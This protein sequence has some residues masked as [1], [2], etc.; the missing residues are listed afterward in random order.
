MKVLINPHG[1]GACPLCKFNNNCMYKKAIEDSL[2]HS[3][4]EEIMEIVIYQCPKFEFSD[5]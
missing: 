5:N 4:L 1:N 2:N 3:S